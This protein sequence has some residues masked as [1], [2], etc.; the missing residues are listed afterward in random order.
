MVAVGGPVRGGPVLVDVVA[1][2]GVVPPAPVD[3]GVVAPGGVAL[4]TCFG[5]W[6]LNLCLFRL[7]LLGLCTLCVELVEGPTTAICS[8]LLRAVDREGDDVD[9]S[10]T[11]T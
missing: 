9:R 1:V 5:P 2:G 10:F 11:T 7:G 6:A 3:D 8:P 4:R